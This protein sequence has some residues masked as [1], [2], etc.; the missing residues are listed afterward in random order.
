MP[1]VTCGADGCDRQAT[2]RGL[3]PMHRYRW[4]RYGSTEPRTSEYWFWLKVNRDGPGGCWL[5]TAGMDTNGYGNFRWGGKMGK[6]HRYSYELHV[7]PIPDGLQIDH[8]CRVRNCVNPAHLE[9]VTIRENVL[10]SDNPCAH[11]ARKTH[12]PQGH[13]YEGENLGLAKNG[14]YC[15]ACHRAT[16]KRYYRRKKGLA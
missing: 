4:A 16:A 6:A 3:C 7:G 5:W 2:H 8:L 15:R 12:C 13:P 10:R 1:N 9:A 11:H 14:R